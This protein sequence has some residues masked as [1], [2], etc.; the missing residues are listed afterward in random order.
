M[1]STYHRMKLA[2]HSTAKT[3]K[4]S[5]TSAG[6]SIDPPML[7]VRP[8]EELHELVVR[9][10]GATV[11]LAT[12]AIDESRGDAELATTWTD[13]NFDPATPALYY[14]RVLENPVCRWS[15]HDAR[16]VGAELP[17]HVPPSIEERAWSSPIWYTP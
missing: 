6:K 9:D 14:A 5:A 7:E 13:P 16:R 4:S 10:G 12:C 11:D 15:T 8:S 3:W 17:Q 1:P 2:S